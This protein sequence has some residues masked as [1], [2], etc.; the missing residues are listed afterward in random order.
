MN[1]YRTRTRA[2]RSQPNR[3]SSPLGSG[4]GPES[5][6]HS[7]SSINTCFSCRSS[8]SSDHDVVLEYRLSLGDQSYLILRAGLV[9]IPEVA[10]VRCS[11]WH[12][13]RHIGNRLRSLGPVQR[14]GILPLVG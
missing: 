7:F 12:L 8:L 6:H 9:D 14:L 4:D 2:I 13:M 1:I 10:L 11:R 3:P 5:P